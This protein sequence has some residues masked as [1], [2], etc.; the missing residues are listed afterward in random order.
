MFSLT[1][2]TSTEEEQDNVILSG[3]L[4]MADDRNHSFVS[5]LLFA[6]CLLI[7]RHSKTANCSGCP[8]L[9]YYYAYT[10]EQ[11]L[12]EEFRSSDAGTDCKV[13]IRS[14]KYNNANYYLEVTWLELQVND[15]MPD[16]KSSYID[17]RL[18]R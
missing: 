15:D 13:G 2:T 1:A 10:S 18:T 16:C 7:L 3:F 4:Q 8:T 9:P 14:S 12:Q 5:S 6:S 17:V 11:E